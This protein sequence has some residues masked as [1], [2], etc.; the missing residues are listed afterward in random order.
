MQNHNLVRIGVKRLFAA[1]T[2]IFGPRI[3][4]PYIKDQAKAKIA[5][6][7]LTKYVPRIMKIANKN[8]TI[9]VP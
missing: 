8:Q 5:M 3:A 7:V 9:R 1:D 4:I 2:F 6:Y